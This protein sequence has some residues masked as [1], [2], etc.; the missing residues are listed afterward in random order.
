LRYHQIGSLFISKMALVY[1]SIDG[2]NNWALFDLDWTLI[3][4]IKGP[5]FTTGVGWVWLP[6]RKEVLQQLERNGFRI[7]VITNQKPWP[8]QPLYIIQSRLVEVWT[9]LKSW[10]QQEPVILA[11]TGNDQYRKPDIG[12][13]SNI[14]FLD[15]S[16]SFYCGDAAGRPDDFSDS[17]IKFAQNSG[18]RF[19]LPEEIFPRTN[20]PNDL[21]IIPRILIILV[22][23]PGAGKTTFGS[24]LQQHGWT[25]ISSDNYGSNKNRIKTA[26]R[27]ALQPASPGPKVI[28]DATN[29]TI[30]GR[31]EYIAIGESFQVPVCIIHVLNSGNERNRLRINP[32]PKIA[33]NVYWSKFETPTT[34]TDH[35]PVYELL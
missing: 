18:L 17:D 32:V 2:P 30:N 15:K 23:A 11:A 24:L 9:E 14:Q 5:M 4:P 27:T 29:G 21:Y 20:I 33:Q 10:L 26:L 16:K 31:A 3:R 28:L 1:G 12:W 35:V 34:I 6:G 19:Y 25:V 22:G 7:G 13:L 8:K